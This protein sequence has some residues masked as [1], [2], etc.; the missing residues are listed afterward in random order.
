[1]PACNAVRPYR[2]AS[3]QQ[4]QRF[5]RAKHCGR[6]AIA[7]RKAGIQYFKFNSGFPIKLGMT[8]KF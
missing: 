1:V 8:E 4:M 6:V 5:W 2:Y 7:G 3:P